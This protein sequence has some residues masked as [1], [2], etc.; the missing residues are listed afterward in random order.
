MKNLKSQKV[1]NLALGIYL[2]FSILSLGF[3]AP[4][5]LAQNGAQYN[6][7]EPLPDLQKVSGDSPFV[8]YVSKIIPFLLA[9]AAL[10]AF[11]QIVFGGI[12]RATSGGNPSA[13]GD[14]NDRIW[15]AILGLVL[16]LS[17]YLILRTI[18]PDLVSLRFFVPK[19]E[20]APSVITVT[21]EQRPDLNQQCSI[22][23]GCKPPYE[24]SLSAS[25]PR[26]IPPTV[27]EERKPHF[28]DEK[29]EPAIGCA[30]PLL[31]TK[32]G[33]GESAEYRCKN[34]STV[35]QTLKG[36]NQ[37]CDPNLTPNGGCLSE[38][39]CSS[40]PNIDADI[41]VCK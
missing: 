24:C 29:C 36:K 27:P 38:F 18:N 15:M 33:T 5:A 14:A 6:L 11:V 40:V 10:A 13:I 3:F 7:I 30:L 35:P 16:A 34:P 2:G 41:S 22:G 20:I 8:E 23:V 32:I 21:N 17:A 19:V 4:V 12:L 25:P 28:I 31:C 1:W 26:C 9:F 37:I 39:K